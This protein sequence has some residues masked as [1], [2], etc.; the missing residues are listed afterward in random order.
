MRGG[1]SKAK[2]LVELDA[3]GAAYRE[4]NNFIPFARTKNT[5]LWAC[6]D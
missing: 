2:A 4:V 3:G 1:L 6:Y 5:P